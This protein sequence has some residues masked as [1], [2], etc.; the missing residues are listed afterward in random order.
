MATGPTLKASSLWLSPE[1]RRRSFSL[2]HPRLQGTPHLLRVKTGGGMSSFQPRKTCD[3]WVSGGHG[4]GMTSGL[5][6][7]RVHCPRPWF[8]IVFIFR[9][10]KKTTKT[11]THTLSWWNARLSI[12]V[13]EYVH[14]R[15]LS[16]LFK[17]SRNLCLEM[18]EYLSF[19][20]RFAACNDGT[21]T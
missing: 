14:D 3:P 20:N 11:H 8:L 7:L 6:L 18:W 1:N 10:K 21:Y 4:K 17:W 13:I 2:W 15:K 12:S 19:G 5:W 16:S 9:K